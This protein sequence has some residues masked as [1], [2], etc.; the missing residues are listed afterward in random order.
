MNNFS[1]SS[2]KTIIFDGNAG[3]IRLESFAEIVSSALQGPLSCGKFTMLANST[4]GRYFNIG[5]FSFVSRSTIG[6]YTSIGSRVSVGPLNHPYRRP[7]A[8]E[9]TYTDFTDFFGVSFTEVQRTPFPVKDGTIR[10]TIGSDVWI[11]DNSVILCGVDI[12]HGCV[13]GAGSIVTK[14]TE[15]YGVYVGNPARLLKK[16]YTQPQIDEI[17]S[18]EWWNRD[19]TDF[20]NLPLFE[21]YEAFVAAV[22]SI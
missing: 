19:I 20:P 12:A 6:N 2:P 3:R 10:A 7:V 16:R 14:S 22:K 18:L 8:N 4:I 5:S 15:P 13:I 21:S 9:I 11:G 17:C 1:N